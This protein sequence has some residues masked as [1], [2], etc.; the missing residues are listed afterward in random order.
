MK[1]L[2]IALIILEGLA[3]NAGYSAAAKPT[4]GPQLAQHYLDALPCP[5]SKK[6]AQ[7]AYDRFLASS[8]RNPRHSLSTIPVDC[9]GQIAGF[10]GARDTFSLVQASKDF[11]A[12]A[13]NLKFQAFLASIE[14]TLRTGSEHLPT[15]SKFGQALSSSPHLRSRF[16]KWL[17][18][19]MK[20]TGRLV[21]PSRGLTR[22]LFFAYLPRG[23][24]GGAAASAASASSAAGVAASATPT[25]LALDVDSALSLLADAKRERDGMLDEG[26]ALSLF[27][28]ENPAF[29]PRARILHDSPQSTSSRSTVS[30]KSA[31]PL[32]S[33]C[34]KIAIDPGYRYAEA[35]EEAEAAN[36]EEDTDEEFEFELEDTCQRAMFLKPVV[37]E[38]PWED[39]PEEG[40]EE[41]EAV[42][43]SEWVPELTPEQL[44][45]AMHQLLSRKTFVVSPTMTTD[46]KDVL[47]DLLEAEAQLYRTVI[48]WM[49][50]EID[51]PR[52]PHAGE[53]L[54]QVKYIIATEADLSNAER[55]ASVE[56]AFHD[57]PFLI[58]ILKIDSASSSLT[59]EGFDLSTLSF[60]STVTR[61]SLFDY[62]TSC[63]KLVGTVPEI[64]RDQVSEFDLSGLDNLLEIGPDCFSDSK[65]LQK[66]TFPPSLKIIGAQAF[67]GCISLESLELSALQNLRHVRE[68]CFRNCTR[69]L[70]ADLSGCTKLANLGD[71]AFY[72]C[73]SLERVSFWG[74][75]LLGHLGN[76]CFGDSPRLKVVDFS[77]CENLEKLGA[78]CFS[79]T[80]LERF[81]LSA[82]IRLS[83]IGGECF[84]GYLRVH[85]ISPSDLVQDLVQAR[86]PWR[87]KRRSVFEI[88]D[89]DPEESAEG[90][91]EAEECSVM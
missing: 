50:E 1:K 63:I 5:L 47:V 40:E 14:K 90:E 80:G 21:F 70:S 42:E 23:D 78:L 61:I 2:L 34:V 44:E 4:T 20:N 11:A 28:G 35:G 91:A 8:S 12:E 51:A 55:R 22:D 84:E 79:N 67:W 75:V 10:L 88:L 41:Y 7:A 19:R 82:C 54:G 53:A 68:W 31:I 6:A 32:E 37:A 66:I 64:L 71:G 52:N 13:E 49:E 36:A 17:S 69:L 18:K 60:P 76:N 15:V 89:E 65:A 86:L 39:E 16:K 77:L 25:C 62:D 9:I 43:F 85:I 46:Q 27:D 72:D 48:Q 56:K 24:V 45:I 26:V 73:P 57:N 3:Y 30:L 58:L 59:E 87:V 38:A 29:E 33:G 74:D 81:N 83:S